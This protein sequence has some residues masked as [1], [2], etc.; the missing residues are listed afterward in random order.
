MKLLSTLIIVLLLFIFYSEALYAIPSFARKYDM[1]CNVCHSPAPKLK[2][3]GEDFAANGFQLPDKE[4][5]RYFRETGDELLLL[6]REFPVSMRFELYG[7][8]TSDL[9]QKPDL[10]TPYILKLLSGGQIARDV[11]YYFYF[12]FSERGEIAGIEDAFIVF[13]NISGP[14]LDLYVGQFQVSDPLFKR[15]L[16]LELE[17]YKAY[18]TKVGE[19]TGRLTYD[20]GI[21]LTYGAPTKTDIILEILNGNGLNEPSEGSFDN[22]KYKNFLLRIS[23][24]LFEGLRIGVFG[25]LGKEQPEDTT[26]VNDYWIAGP[27]ATI[28][29]GPL[30]LNLQYVLRE[31]KNPD[32]LIPKPADKITTNGGFAE[33][34]YSPNGDKSNWY[35]GLLY[36]NVK[37]DYPGLDYESISVNGHYL[38]GRNL[39]LIGEY[40]YLT[41]TETTQI[42]LGLFSAF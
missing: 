5:P 37:S 12:F 8:Y 33:L 17:D 27:D 21:M 24:D 9:K 10:Q 34:I 31:D 39:R 26:G 20:R 1:S 32:F 23:Q 25:Y 16:R 28:E 13:N 3:Y 14:D 38:I 2:P 15:E 6:M 35:A 4:P 19:T 30:Q 36:N 42:T 41:K 40:A 7:K 22:D 18:S 29:Y 11:A